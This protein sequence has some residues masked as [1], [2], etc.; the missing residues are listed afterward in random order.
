MSIVRLVIIIAKFNKKD[1]I[2]TG[3]SLSPYRFVPIHFILV[4]ALCI[5]ATDWSV[6]LLR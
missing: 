1:T 3:A 2:Y 5:T 4:D 6:A